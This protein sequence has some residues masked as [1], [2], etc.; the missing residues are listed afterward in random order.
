MY[1]FTLAGW[2]GL[3]TG[4]GGAPAPVRG[5]ACMAPGSGLGGGLGGLGTGVLVQA[6][7]NQCQAGF[8]R[9]H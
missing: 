6:S 7:A 4:L 5:G 1:L 9:C 8:W 3:R 2:T